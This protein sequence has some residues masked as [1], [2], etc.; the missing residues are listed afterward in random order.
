MGSSAS[1]GRHSGTN[2]DQKIVSIPHQ[3][4]N[5]HINALVKGLSTLRKTSTLCDV[6]LSVN[7][8]EKGPLNKYHAHR[9][10][11]AASSVYFREKLGV[12]SAEFDEEQPPTPESKTTPRN[13]VTT[14][15]VTID[16]PISHKAMET[17]LQY[18]YSAVLESDPRDIPNVVEAAVKLGID[19]LKRRCIAEIQSGFQLEYFQRILKLSEQLDLSELKDF[20]LRKTIGQFDEFVD[21]H[22][23]LALTETD[24]QELVNHRKGVLSNECVIPELQMF[25][26]ILKWSTKDTKERKESTLKLLKCLHYAKIPQSSL[27]NYVLTQDIVMQ[28]KELLTMIEGLIGEDKKKILQRLKKQM[29]TTAQPSDKN[30]GIG[31][32]NSPLHSYVIVT[33]GRLYDQFTAQIQV[34]NHK[35]QTWKELTRLPSTLCHHSVAVVGNVLYV[36]GGEDTAITGVKGLASLWAYY[37]MKNEWETLPDMIQGRAHFYMSAQEQCLVVVGGKSSNVV[38]NSVEKFS[39][40]TKKWEFAAVLKQ[41]R[42]SHAGSSYKHDLYVS[43]GVVRKS[44][45]QDMLKYNIATNH[46]VAVAKMKCARSCHTMAAVRDRIYVFGGE[47]ETQGVIQH[48]ATAIECYTPQ[49]DQWHKVAQKTISQCDKESACTELDG[50]VYL[51]GGCK[52]NVTDHR[53]DTASYN[54]ES[55]TWATQPKLPRRLRGA[56]CAVLALK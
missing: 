34:L 51:V 11:L 32:G 7:E 38:R 27:T 20:A 43:G 31:D 55:D 10:V 42:Y 26:S 56:A 1:K 28:D 6:T 47:N 33:G 46:W 4:S 19:S 45:T 40:L 49:C 39:I 8:T 52:T 2:I 35:D 21:T 14:D 9:C 3:H 44:S 5:E 16:F 17:V 29:S 18:I 54:P 41:P 36:A 37:P 24:M 22:C 23:F 50:L 15:D 48:V 53:I 30:G 12:S 25:N 13:D